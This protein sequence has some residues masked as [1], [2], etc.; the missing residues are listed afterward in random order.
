MSVNLINFFRIEWK[1]YIHPRSADLE[2]MRTSSKAALKLPQFVPS[3]VVVDHLRSHTGRRLA[4]ERLSEK[5]FVFVTLPPPPP[6]AFLSHIIRV[7]VFATAQ[8][9]SQSSLPGRA[10][11]CFATLFSGLRAS[12]DAHFT[13]PTVLSRRYR[14]IILPKIFLK[15]FLKATFFLKSEAARDNHH[16][17]HGF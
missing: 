3:H 1:S 5:P 12:R 4:K 7:R 8:S 9:R 14:S 15:F 16:L 10:I 2:F 6:H 17:R 11:N 13:L